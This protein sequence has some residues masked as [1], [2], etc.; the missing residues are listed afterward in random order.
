MKKII[1]ISDTHYPLYNIPENFFKLFLNDT[2][3][4]IIHCGDF[5]DYK[6][7]E[8]LKKI[9]IPLYIVLGNNDN[10]RVFVSNFSKELIINVENKLIGITH[11]FGFKN[12]LQNVIIKFKKKQ[13]D[14]VCFGHTHIICN[15][16]FKKCL[17]FN[18]GS[19][20]GVRTGKKTYG[21][22]YI[23]KNFINGEIKYIK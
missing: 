9:K 12:V 13:L 21:I 15:T 4:G 7:F 20:S 8:R 6:L 22:L 16:I 3:D 5:T 10:S 14:C 19:L 18:P 11:G 2:Y 23:E 17:Y 1:V